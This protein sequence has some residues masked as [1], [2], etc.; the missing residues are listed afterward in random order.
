MKMLET[1]K[2]LVGIKSKKEKLDAEQARN[3][4]EVFRKTKEAIKDITLPEV[5]KYIKNAERMHNNFIKTGQYTAAA[6]MLWLMQVAKA[7]EVMVGAGITKQIPVDLIGDIC[8]AHPS[9]AVK[10][11]NLEDYERELPESVIEAKKAVE[12]VFDLFM[13]IYTDHTKK[14]KA[15][16]IQKTRDPILVGLFKG[17]VKS[18]KEPEPGQPDRRVEA[19]VIS[20]RLYVI[21]SWEDD[22]CDLTLDRLVR[23]SAERG[24]TWDDSVTLYIDPAARLEGMEEAFAFLKKAGAKPADDN[25]AEAL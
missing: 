18:G 7:E 15:A 25:S 2:K 17:V 22:K 1:I 9:R 5:K 20:D 11:C 8:D 10:V 3:A 16:N 21:A 13:V 14:Q 4:M 23:E 6:K 12:D 19:S 24:I